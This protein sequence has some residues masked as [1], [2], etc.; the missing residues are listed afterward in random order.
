MSTRDSYIEKMKA[1]LDELNATLNEL[2]VNAHQAKNDVHEKYLA[3]MSKLREQS[4]LAI[5]KLDE[6][7][8]GGE[9]SWKSMVADTEKV[10]DA[11]VKSFHYFKSQ[12]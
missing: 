8:T 6:L 12:L 3:E 10:R 11:F 7:K 4:Q 1:Q 9:E 2:E 5:E